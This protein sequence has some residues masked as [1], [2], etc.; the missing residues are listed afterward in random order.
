[1]GL[2]VSLRPRLDV[3]L[4]VVDKEGGHAKLSDERQSMFSFS[5]HDI[6]VVLSTH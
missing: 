1:M 5:K 4:L 3:L 6:I 2:S